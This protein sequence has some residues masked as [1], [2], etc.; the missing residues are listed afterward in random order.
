MKAAGDKT[1]TKL[2][3]PLQKARF[4]LGKKA[5]TIFRKS[6]FLT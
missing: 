6:Y 3:L 5:K 1:K 4:Y 2:M